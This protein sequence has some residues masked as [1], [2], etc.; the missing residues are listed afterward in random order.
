MNH[1][2]SIIFVLIR[3]FLSDITTCQ[4]IQD[5]HLLSKVGELRL[6]LGKQSTAFS[7]NL[8]VFNKPEEDFLFVEQTFRN[9]ID[10]YSLNSEMYYKTIHL[11]KSIAPEQPI[12]FFVNSFDSIYVLLTKS[13]KLV[14]LNSNGVII[15]ETKTLTKN[16][17]I[18]PVIFS[19]HPVI[20][21][22]RNL[23][24]CSY[25]R[26][27][28]S[29]LKSPSCI[30]FNMR[31]KT[32]H[33]DNPVSLEYRKGWWG[34]TIY[35]PT[36]H[37][38]YNSNKKLIVNSFPVDNYIYVYDKFNELTRYFAGSQFIKK[39]NPISKRMN[40]IISGSDVENH[41]AR[42]GFYTAINYDK[43][44]NIY[45]RCLVKPIEKSQEFSSK[46]DHAIV[47][48]DKNFS[49]LG[50]WEVPNENDL[51]KSFIYRKGLYIFNTEL[52]QQNQDT[53]YFDI[54]QLRN[55]NR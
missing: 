2:L 24:I 1:Y 47:I 14:L 18:T 10:I 4:I 31:D 30:I 23:L 25:F 27:P 36:L 33:Y 26:V 7:Y 35:I 5:N 54:Y 55:S 43:Y 3:I 11:P 48:L 52:Y 39:V 13:N 6:P 37:Q 9:A 12:G 49:I 46:R 20:R 17:E 28:N 51:F 53:L 34:E 45:Y 32:I 44:Q 8:Q 40:P 42:S 19:N 15:E 16:T 29:L 21:I 22:E 38:T 50:E 41:Y